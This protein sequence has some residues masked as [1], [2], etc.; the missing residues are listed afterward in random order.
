M[1]NFIK[2]RL[3]WRK[4]PGDLP[5]SQSATGQ[6]TNGGRNRK[7]VL[8]TI[9]VALG[10]VIVSSGV[11]LTTT[12]TPQFCSACHEMLPEF[13]TWKISS[14]SNIACVTCHIP[15]GPGNL[16]K[17]K[18][19]S[20]QQLAEHLSGAMP[21]PIAMNEPISNSVCEQC[22]T[23]NRKVTASGDI[24]I[25][26]DKHLVQGIACVAC[27]GGVAHGFIAERG[28][29]EKKDYNTWTL[30][31]A[32]T[33]MKFDET[34]TA[35]EVCLDC[36]EQAR[37]GLRPWVEHK[38]QGT[39]EKERISQNQKN[40]Q[41]AASTTGELAHSL[42]SAVSATGTNIFHPPTTK[43]EGCHSAIPTPNSHKESGWSITHGVT[44]RKDVS[45]CASCHS[46]QSE[47]AQVTRRTD[48]AD[49]ARSN[50]FCSQC[51]AKRPG[52]HM[53]NKQAWMPVHPNAIQLKGAANCL[54]CHD[55]DKST[56][57]KKP[58]GNKGQLNLSPSVNPV[59]CN[60]CH[61]FQG[62]N[63]IH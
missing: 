29:T 26:H 58:D 24:I 54:T 48:V 30:S 63:D 35:M 31:K 10:A 9:F 20:I 5:S 60:L 38:G 56:Q 45:Y 11:G 55:L 8:I 25:P 22:H 46:R 40:V 42:T 47:R 6:A 52:T 19:S 21:Q 43:C 28:L 15:P 3:P 18:I 12:N 34:K 33:V 7:R 13:Q 14:H 50:A 59:Y 53:A 49:Y 57:T 32:S 23:L 37:Q 62:P 51:H 4:K 1:I 39:T 17:H 2:D 44:G 16:V 61:W 27:H 41:T 36:H